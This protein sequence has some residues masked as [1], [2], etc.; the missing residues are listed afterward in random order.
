M[1]HSGHHWGL[2]LAIAFIG[3]IAT[4]ASEGEPAAVLPLS[5]GVSFETTQMNGG[6]SSSDHILHRQPVHQQPYQQQQQPYYQHQQQRP[7]TSVPDPA[8]ASSADVQKLYEQANN[9][10]AI[11]YLLLASVDPLTQ[12]LGSSNALLPYLTPVILRLYASHPDRCAATVTKEL[13][14]LSWHLYGASPVLKACHYDL[15]QS[16][17]VIFSW[18]RD[19][20]ALKLQHIPDQPSATAAWPDLDLM[21][22]LDFSSAVSGALSRTDTL[23]GTA[24]VLA[25]G[26]GFTMGGTFSGGGGF[27]SSSTGLGVVSSPSTAAAAAG[28][29]TIV[30]VN[31]DASVDSLPVLVTRISQVLKQLHADLP[32]LQTIAAQMYDSGWTTSQ[33]QQQ[34]QQQQRRHDATATAAAATVPME[35]TPKPR[36]T[37]NSPRRRGLDEKNVIFVQ[38]SSSSADAADVISGNQNEVVV[39]DEKISNNDN[40]RVM[41]QSIASGRIYSLPTGFNVTSPAAM[42]PLLV[43]LV[44][45]VMLYKESYS[46]S[47]NVIGPADFGKAPVFLD[48]IVRQLNLMSMPTNIQFFIKEIR[49]NATAYPRLLLP[50]RPT[51]LNFPFCKGS[52]CLSDNALVST[53]VT[54]WPRSI[55]IFVGSDTTTGNTVMGYAFVPA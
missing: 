52:G 45:H 38:A 2:F 10:S 35:T 9:V 17:K 47:T 32:L 51:W 26:C 24:A 30:R 19:N 27:S 44:F 15:F 54:D 53:V 13:Y 12:A 41:Q 40:R 3:N 22:L 21:G 8:S 39:I 48:R 14:E 42:P 28:P 37:I 6:I 25:A 29:A 33:Q 43:P 5:S 1:S 36:S 18:V 7:F 55:N 23:G 11:A 4:T 46:G 16:L 20:I 49:N 31:D 50:D 34:Q